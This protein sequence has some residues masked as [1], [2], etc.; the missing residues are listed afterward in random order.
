L[1]IRLVNTDRNDA[2]ILVKKNTSNSLELVPVDHGYCL[3]DFLEIA[4]CDWCWLDWPQVKEPFSKQMLEYIATLD[5]KSDVDLLR[6][7][8]SIREES[9]KVMEI[10][11]YVLQIGAGAGLTLHQIGKIISRDNLDAPSLLEITVEQAMS[12]AT[13]TKKKLRQPTLTRSNTILTQ[14]RKCMSWISEGRADCGCEHT[15]DYHGPSVSH[16]VQGG[17][18]SNHGSTRSGKCLTEP[19]DDAFW[20]YFDVLLKRV[21]QVSSK[22]TGNRISRRNS[23]Y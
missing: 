2:N 3:P 10:C 12:L 7:T 20:R 13:S 14:C 11:G 6:W 23:C 8:L 4:W 19:L 1:D 9:L 16:S 22:K 17:S 5:V 18:G 15:S 21:I